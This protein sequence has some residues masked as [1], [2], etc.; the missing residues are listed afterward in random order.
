ME[1]YGESSIAVMPFVNMSDDAENEYFSDGMAEELLNLLAKIPRLRVI[2]QSSSFSFKGKGFTIPQVAAQLNVGFVLEGSVRKFGNK[3]RI[4]AQLIEARSDTHLWSETYDRTLDDLFAIQDEIS[5]AIVDQLKGQLKLDIGAAPKAT[6]TVNTEAHDAALRGRYLL[7][8]RKRGTKVRAVAEFEKALSLDPG[9]ALAHAELSMALLLGGCGDMTD[10]QCMASIELHVEQAMAL[11]PGLAEAHA[12][13]AF[14]SFEQS[15]PDEARVHFRRA[16]E[17][18]PNYAQAY[19]WM[20]NMGL[21]SSQEEAFAGREAAARLDPLSPLSNYSYIGA[22]LARNRLEQAN[23]QIEQ[24]ESI[25]PK[26]AAVLRAAVSS[27]GGHWASYILEYL[28]LASGGSEALTYSWGAA[29][30]MMWQLAAIGLEDEALRMSDGD[31]FEVQMWLGDPEAAIALAQAGLKDD[32]DNIGAQLNMAHTL[33]HAGRYQEARPWLEKGWHFFGRITLEWG[34]SSF[35]GHIAQALIATLRE[36]GD[37]A[38]ANRVLAEFRDYVHQ[39]RD[40]GIVMT[41]RDTSVDFLEGIIAYLAGE[42]DK[43]LALISKAAEEGYWIRPPAAFQQTMY[44]DPGF[45]AILE[46]QKVRQAREREK[47]LAVACADDYPYAAVW[48]PTEETCKRYY[49]AGHH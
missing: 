6:G 27:L 9:F 11:D 44:Q 34:N 40:A 23:Q 38:G 3:L 42:R 8:Q 2:S 30:D 45:A 33:A 32:P 41:G 12:A 28:E 10:D 7:A 20:A 5:A 47:V 43:G 26:G 37:V 24:Y 16:I 17:I 22:L 48:Q 39:Y 4:T 25:D 31:N 18:N 13:K 36:A 14:L 15:N 46:G 19:V 29:E 21:F 49:S 1:S 35:M